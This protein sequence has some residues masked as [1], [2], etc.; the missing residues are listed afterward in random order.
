MNGT[1]NLQ[2]AHGQYFVV[3]GGPY[4]LKP[5]GYI[6]VKMAKEIQAPAEIDIPTRDFDT[7]PAAEMD[8]GLRQAV[9]RILLGQPLYVGCMGG[10]GRTGLFLAILAK[11]F[12]EPDPVAYVRKNYM[13]HA[14][15]TL[16]QKAYVAAYVIP[17]GLTK[18]IRI[19]RFFWRFSSKNLLTKVVNHVR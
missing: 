14:V 7:P 6:G 11:A 1:L 19:A 15:E 2:L 8:H 5:P 16:E 17:K 4:R 9:N 10:I 13:G 18:K 3:A 12:G